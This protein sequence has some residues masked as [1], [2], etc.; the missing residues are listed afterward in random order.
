MKHMLRSKFR[1]SKTLAETLDNLFWSVR[2]TLRVASYGYGAAVR[3]RAAAYS[4]IPSFQHRVRAHVVSVGNI[5]VGGTGKTP[6][7]QYIA[8]RYI[9]MGHRVAVLCRPAPTR[10]VVVVSDGEALLVNDWEHTGDEP[11][12]IARKV[13][14]AIVMVCADRLRSARMAVNEY[15]AE[16]IV[17]DDGFQHMRLARDEDIVVLD[18]TQPLDMLHLLPRGTL[19]EPPGALKRATRIVLT[20]TDRCADHDETVRLVK[21]YAPNVPITCTTHRTTEVRLLSRRRGQSDLAPLAGRRVVVFSAIGNPSSFEHSVAATG[22]ETAC[23]IRF[24]DHHVYAAA[25]VKQIDRAVDQHQAD[26][27]VTTE[28]DAIRLSEESV[29]F[30]LYTMGVEIA[31]TEGATWPLSDR[32]EK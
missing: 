27:A 6:V 2:G 32:I 19:R 28:K 25:D 24:A 22:A 13:P 11:Q 8:G 12:L 31:L 10:G 20:H 17:L 5:T 23:T 15:R 9:E 29:P 14:G 7:T 3:V 1:S 4:G 30:P 26:A 21:R 18:A 16:V